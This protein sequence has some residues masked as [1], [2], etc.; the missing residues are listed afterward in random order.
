LTNGLGHGFSAKGADPGFVAPEGDVD[1]A[2]PDDFVA[3][4]HA[5]CAKN[6]FVGI[7]I[8]GRNGAVDG[9]GRINAAQT[10]NRFFCHTH[11]SCHLEQLAGPAFITGQAVIGMIGDGHLHD[12]LADALN[13]LGLGPDHHAV[14]GDGGARRCQSTQAFDGHDTQTAGA[15]RLQDGIVTEGRHIKSGLFYGSE[16]GGAFGHPCFLT[17]NGQQD[18]LQNEASFDKGLTVIF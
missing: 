7:Q 6:A 3:D 18:G 4:P 12:G 13:L 8:K 14:L 5:F 11:I 15:V 2:H 10:S 1:G 16:D 17:V 9:F